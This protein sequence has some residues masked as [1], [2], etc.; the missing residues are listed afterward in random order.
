M[1]QLGAS[2]VLERR[3]DWSLFQF[4]GLVIVPLIA[5]RKGVHM[6]VVEKAFVAVT[7]RETLSQQNDNT[8][9][10]VTHRL[11][12]TS[13]P[14]HMNTDLGAD[15]EVGVRDEL[16]LFMAVVLLFQEHVQ[17]AHANSR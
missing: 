14:L 16:W 12:C 13:L 15:A 9:T 7:P 3:E 2:V 1:S 17:H 6:R 11:P 4:G 8:I 5:V 10:A